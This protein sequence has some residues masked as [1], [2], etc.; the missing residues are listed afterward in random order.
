MDMGSSVETVEDSLAVSFEVASG[1]SAPRGNAS[2]GPEA[3]TADVSCCAACAVGDA[4]PDDGDGS[5]SDGAG[6]RLSGREV[7]CE[8]GTETRVDAPEMDATGTMGETGKLG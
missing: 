8:G 4:E 3:D 7:A 2:D 6:G 1:L 5:K